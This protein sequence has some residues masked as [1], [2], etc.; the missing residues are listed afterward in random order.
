MKKLCIFLWVLILIFPITIQANSQKTLFDPSQFFGERL[1][2]AD[3]I[4]RK[5][6]QINL[7]LGFPL[8]YKLIDETP[9]KLKVYT[10][11]GEKI[12]EFSFK[13]ESALFKLNK[14]IKSNGLWIEVSLYYCKQT[15][16]G[17]CLMRNVLYEV[18]LEFKKKKENIHLKYTL[19]DED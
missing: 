19:P 18:P 4:S 7:N 5:V 14:T 15:D 13:K 17:L 1:K 11:V 2:L 3:P 16:T 8:G 9:S 6:N 12:A 10:Q